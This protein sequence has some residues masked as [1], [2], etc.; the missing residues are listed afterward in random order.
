[1]IIPNIIDTFSR[2]KATGTS[3]IKINS[4]S[5]MPNFIFFFIEFHSLRYYFISPF[6]FCV[7]SFID[8]E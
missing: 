2:N 4:L 7:S 6:N 3:D 8:Q 1:M 5:I